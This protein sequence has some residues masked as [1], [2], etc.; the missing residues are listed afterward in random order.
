MNRLRVLGRGLRFSA[1][2]V[3]CW[4]GMQGL[5]WAQAGGSAPGQPAPEK[6][7]AYVAP[8]ALV[9]VCVG[10]ALAIVLNSSRRRDRAKPEVFGEPK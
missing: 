1:I 9:I 8:Y 4:L 3:L 10:I 5:S 6:P 2:A 7:P